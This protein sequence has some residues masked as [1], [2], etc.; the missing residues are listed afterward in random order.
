M[1]I[2]KPIFLCL[3]FS[4]FLPILLRGQGLD[5]KTNKPYNEIE[6]LPIFT[7]EKG[8]LDEPPVPT[9]PSPDRPNSRFSLK[10]FCPVPADQG[11]TNSCL[12][13]ASVYAAYT[14]S[15]R[16][17]SEVAT[18]KAFSAAYM[19]NMIGERIGLTFEAA[20]KFMYENGNCPDAVFS[21][22]NVQTK[23]KPDKIAHEIAKKN[24]LPVNSFRA[25]KCD[26]KSIVD[27]LK[28]KLPVV[29]GVKLEENFRKRT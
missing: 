14:I 23:T 27:K 18:K 26:T 16:W 15:K 8:F 22:Q 12:A 3:F 13:F 11:A 29:I 4:V 17:E 10:R 24:T 1:T 2:I 20:F 7:G 9:S 21:N 28:C 19:F 25:I 5:I 6:L